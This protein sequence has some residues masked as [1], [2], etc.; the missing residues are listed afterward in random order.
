MTTRT[1][2]MEPRTLDAFLKPKSVAIIGLSRSAIGAPVSVLT[3]LGDL[4]YAGRVWVVNPGLESTAT[5]RACPT[6]A[7]I[8][9]PVD[10]AIVSVERARVHGVLEECVQAGIR[11]ALVITQGFAD[12]DEEG[13]RLQDAIVALARRTGLRILGPNTIGVVNS[14]ERFTSSFIEVQEDR[15]PIGQVSQSGLFMMGHHLINNEPAGYCLSVDLGNGCDIGLVDVLE[16]FEHED[17]VRV[18]QCHVEG[19]VDG[20]G[21]L[22]TVSRITR[23]KPVIALKAGTTAAGQAA[24]ASHTGAV[25]GAKEVYAAAF[26]KAGVVPA[27]DAEELRLLSK[28]F[29]I[30]EPPKG[31]RVAIMSF[32]GG[33]AILAIDALDRAGLVLATLSEA[34]RASLADLFSGWI[35]VHNPLDIWMPV[36]KDFERAF[37]RVLEALLADPQVDAVLCIYCSYRLPK[38]ALYDSSRHIGPIAAKHR[39]KPVLCWTYGL[40]IEGFTRKVEA[41]GPTM[42]F[43]SLDDAAM[44]LSK[45]AD[46]GERR[47]R[48][49]I[50]ALAPGNGT[51]E[52]ASSRLITAARADARRYLFTEA[53]EILGSY[54]LPLPPWR[55]VRD[56]AGLDEAVRSLAFPLCLKVVSANVVHKSDAGGVRLGLRDAGELREA[57]RAMRREVAGRSPGAR[58][59]GFV[60]QEMAPRGKEV[61][62]GM[63][64]D[65]VF[66]PCI[67]FGSGG[68]YAEALDDFAF[69]IAPL[70]AAEA[71]AMIGETRIARILG[72]IR[73]EAPCDLAGV[74]DALVR[75]S[76]LACAHPEIAEID[77]NPLFVTER[78]ATVVDAR[79]ILAPAERA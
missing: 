14:L 76:R 15:T 24:V 50:A 30:Y 17:A 40:D 29:A 5:L 70:D 10:L 72:G 48:P 6:I 18:I 7:A 55:F 44:T 3:S 28:A 69:R 12:A 25:A 73:G 39:S 36:A 66:G 56:D 26:R 57:L 31:R 75:V 35:G 1:T 60:V 43:P 78:G 63:K 13:R 27:A 64:R 46:Y 19:I 9:E 53:L 65:P 77:L 16:Y 74:V 61:L 4:G 67:V 41:G 37:P 11:A 62:I 34:T 33:G 2:A 42:V 51:A 49:A 52:A 21:F 20:P 8:P 68:T 54:G 47:G 79:F 58:I 59:D 71:R 38:Y 45:L 22:E 32:S 23:E